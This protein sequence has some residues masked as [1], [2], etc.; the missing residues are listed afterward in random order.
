MSNRDDLSINL[1]DI[2][3]LKKNTDLDRVCQ[4]LF[5][6]LIL[7]WMADEI[8]AFLG[9][10]RLPVLFLRD[11]RLRLFIFRILA[12]PLILLH[13]EALYGPTTVTAPKSR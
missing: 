6:G 9:V 12:N 1:R 2:F 4:A 5:S 11:K 3:C 13:F 7:G 8:V 10:L